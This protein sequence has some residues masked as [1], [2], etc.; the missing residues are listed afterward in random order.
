MSNYDSGRF[1]TERLIYLL[2]CLLIFSLLQ[3]FLF[4]PHFHSK[5]IENGCGQY[6]PITA[7]FEYINRKGE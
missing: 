7:E 1:S 4:K 5:A 3:I 6:N 2:V